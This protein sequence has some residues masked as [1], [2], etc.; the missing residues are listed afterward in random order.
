MS[1]PCPYAVDA[2]E[3]ATVDEATVDAGTDATTTGYRGHLKYT[4]ADAKKTINA[5]ITYSADPNVKKNAKE[6]V[7][8]ITGVDSPV[9]WNNI[10]KGETGYSYDNPVD[11]D[12]NNSGW[13]GTYLID[14]VLG[15]SN[16]TDTNL[17][18]NKTLG[19][20]KNG[21]KVGETG[22]SFEDYEGYTEK[23]G[24][25]LNGREY[26]AYKVIDLGDNSHYLF[27]GY[28]DGDDAY[29]VQGYEGIVPGFVFDG[30]KIVFNKSGKGKANGSTNESLD[31]AAALVEYKDGTVTE[32]PGVEVAGVKFDTKALKDCDKKAT[33]S[34]QMNKEKWSYEELGT[35]G[36]PKTID[37]AADGSDI[38]RD[39]YK[40][41]DSDLGKFTL[42]VKVKG[43]DID[44]T[45]KKAITDKL[46]TETFDFAISQYVVDVPLDTIETQLFTDQKLNDAGTSLVPS[47]KHKVSDNNANALTEDLFY[48]TKDK[49]E[50]EFGSFKMTKFDQAKGKANVTLTVTT[51]DGKNKWD[52]A[53]IKLKAG[54][55]YELTDG[56]LA[57]PVR[58]LTSRATSYTET[59]E[60]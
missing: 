12:Q 39:A 52:E 37:K 36:K 38:T 29:Q 35:D 48:R 26:A 2:A 45:V 46:K 50:V 43:K 60:L 22:T 23:V 34:G 17:I 4:E 5:E 33:V 3:E 20:S 42:K 21:A 31:V 28:G 7:A 6:N 41:L 8:K 24:N 1:S 27:V 58:L 9:S 19:V 47:G 49:D 32:I 51:Y 44:K 13:F 10:Y 25:K 57:E 55:D 59:Q 30:R 53:D 15:G 14:A 54:T 18:N 11:P 16:E 40:K 56:S